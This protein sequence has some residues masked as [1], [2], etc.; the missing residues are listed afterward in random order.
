[1]SLRSWLLLLLVPIAVPLFSQAEPAQEEQLEAPLVK[2]AVQGG[3]SVIEQEKSKALVEQDDAVRE[4]NAREQLDLLRVE[5]NTSLAKNQGAIPPMDQARLVDLAVELNAAAPQTFEA[6]MANYYTKFPAPVAFQELELAGAK[7]ND[8]E[9]LVAP[10]LVNAARKD[11]ATEL[12]IRAKEMKLRGKI[13]PALYL[14]A[15]DIMASVEPSA[16]LFAAGEMDAY[17]LWVE[18]FADGKRKD[19]LVVDERLLADPAYRLRIWERVK[20]KG[21]VS[22]ESGFIANLSNASERPV[23]LSLSLGQ[24][25][26]MPLKDKLYVTGSAMR[27]SNTAVD[28]IPLLESRWDRLRKPM[29]AGPLSRNYLVPGA[30]LLTHYRT[31]GDEARAARLEHELREMAKR[32]GA[33]ST[34]IKTGVLTH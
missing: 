5:R 22:G 26:M 19:L 23:Y 33:T 25:T 34:L 20:A 4:Q 2:D 24:A 11:N 17:P 12:A 16:V 9:E 21:V 7:A 14:V 29:D 27:L 13:A 28:N 8:R 10:R 18:Q 15:E 31:I 32:L 1:M 30:V 6:H 3:W